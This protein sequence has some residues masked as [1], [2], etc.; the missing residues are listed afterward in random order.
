MA[1]IIIV[2]EGIEFEFNS[3]NAAVLAN[4]ATS[5]MNT[6]NGLKFLEKC[7]YDIS[8]IEVTEKHRTTD[9]T[10]KAPKKSAL[11]ILIERAQQPNAEEIKRL[12]LER[13]NVL[14]SLGSPNV[15]AT[16]LD[17]LIAIQEALRIAKNPVATRESVMALLTADMNAAAF[18]IPHREPIADEPTEL[19][20]PTEP[21]EPQPK[22]R[23]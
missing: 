23:K 6:K 20:E 12:D 7:G 8:R 9:G 4:G 5:G 17:D 18:D 14:E 13:Q 1:K 22:K 16:V 11:D 19:T 2:K 15:S 21:T 10:T 3:I